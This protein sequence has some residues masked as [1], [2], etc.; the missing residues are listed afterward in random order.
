MALA[1]EVQAR[2]PSKLLIQLTQRGDQS[3]TTVNSTLLGYA[4]TDA[5][6]E[7]QNI[8]GVAYDGTDARHVAAAVKLVV[9]L[10]HQWG[11]TPGEKADSMMTQAIEA[12]ERVAK[13]TGRQR[14]RPTSSSVLTPSSELQGTEEV[15][16]D[17]DREA[18]DDYVPKAP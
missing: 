13:V 11:E 3:A 16:P 9:A 8:A 14:I 18:F 15:R 7:F 10:L 4:V 2:Y 1:A 12:C 17:T 6:Y 5:T